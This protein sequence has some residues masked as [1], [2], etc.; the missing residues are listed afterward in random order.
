MKDVPGWVIAFVLTIF[1]LH[2]LR[3]VIVHECGCYVEESDDDDGD[4]DDGEEK[5]PDVDP[6]RGFRTAASVG[7]HRAAGASTVA[8]APHPSAAPSS[9]RW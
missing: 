2:A 8:V 7:W 4:E 9:I 1:A 3:G 6:A 5:A